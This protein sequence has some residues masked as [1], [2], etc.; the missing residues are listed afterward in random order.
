VQRFVTY[1]AGKLC[2]C[3]DHGKD[4]M[5]RNS[6]IRL[7]RPDPAIKDQPFVGFF[8]Q[9]GSGRFARALVKPQPEADTDPYL[10][11]LLADQELVEGRDEQARYLV[12]AA[13]ESFDQ[14]AQINGY[15]SC[16][17]DR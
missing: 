12:E 5:I 1:Q 3:P 15:K 8:K 4:P 16:P 10:L 14:K 9:L 11:L 17:F 7:V 2:L 6:G 13:Y